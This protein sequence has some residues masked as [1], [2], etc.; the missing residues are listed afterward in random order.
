[1]EV[2]VILTDGEEVLTRQKGIK[3]SNDVSDTGTSFWMIGVI[4]YE[5]Y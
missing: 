2:Y 4:R 1:M 3:E 5:L